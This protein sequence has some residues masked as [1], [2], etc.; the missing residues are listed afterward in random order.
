MG[1]VESFNFMYQAR[2]GLVGLIIIIVKFNG[3]VNRF[4]FCMED[5]E[6]GLANIDCHFVRT[7][8][9][10]NFLYFTINALN[11]VLSAEL[12]NTLAPVQYSKYCLQYWIILLRQY[13]ILNTVCSIGQYSGASTVF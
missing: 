7:K 8:P 5:D 11:Q 3:L 4:T 12:D 9:S 10:R 1:C 13:S 6:F 2:I